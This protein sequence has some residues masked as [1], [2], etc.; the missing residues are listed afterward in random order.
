MKSIFYDIKRQNQNREFFEDLK[1]YVEQKQAEGHEV[2]L[3][4]K[5]EDIIAIRLKDTNLIQ[6]YNVKQKLIVRQF[7]LEL[8]EQ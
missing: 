5:N 1:E 6:L 3:P 2:R 8:V 7:N 4:K